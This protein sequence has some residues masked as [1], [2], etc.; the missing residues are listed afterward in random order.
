M[1][2][3]LKS[4]NKRSTKSIVNTNQQLTRLSSETEL[5]NY[6]SSKESVTLNKFAPLPNVKAVLKTT[7]SSASA[8]TRRPSI[9]AIANNVELC[10]LPESTCGGFGEFHEEELAFRDA[11]ERECYKTDGIGLCEM[12]RMETEAMHLAATFRVT[13]YQPPPRKSKKPRYEPIGDITQIPNDV[14]KTFKGGPA[15]ILSDGVDVTMNGIKTMW[16]KYELVKLED[17]GVAIV[18]AVSKR[19]INEHY[20]LLVLPRPAKARK[21]KA[22]SLSQSVKESGTSTNDERALV[23]AAL[24][25][26]KNDQSF[27]KNASFM[28]EMEE[29]SKRV[30]VANPKSR[31]KPRRTAASVAKDFPSKS[32]EKGT[33]KKP[34]RKPKETPRKSRKQQ[35]KESSSTESAEE[36]EEDAEEADEE[37][38]E[39]KRKYEDSESSEMD[40]ELT[41]LAMKTLEVAEHAFDTVDRLVSHSKKRHKK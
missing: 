24:S 16:K 9:P 26:W 31:T 2:R 12:D 14:K 34:P 27:G 8:L 40:I 5:A 41:K 17:D 30:D 35:V 29:N 19:T 10:L 4:T 25:E 22:I 32:R 1:E 33:P 7:E 28:K 36:D 37:E 18:A 15:F 21:I 13:S 6:L 38:E 23:D 20:E 39:V 3:T 11:M